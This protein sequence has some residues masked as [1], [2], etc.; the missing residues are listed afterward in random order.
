MRF[1]EDRVRARYASMV[2]HDL[3]L[4]PPVVTLGEVLAARQRECTN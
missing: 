4:P 1:T 3:V 2:L